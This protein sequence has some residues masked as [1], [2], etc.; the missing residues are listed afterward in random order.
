M[1]DLSTLPLSVLDIGPVM[2]GSSPAATLRNTVDL[3][4]RVEQLGYRRYWVAEHHNAGSSVTSSPAVLAGQL[5][6]ATSRIRIGSGG[7]MLPNHQPLVV[8]EQFGTLAA[9]HPGRIDLGIGR[10]PGADP[11]AALALRRNAAGADFADL[12]SEVLAYMAGGTAVAAYPVPDEWPPVWVLGSSVNGARV[13]AQFGL[14]FAFA[15]Q[16]AAPNTIPALRAYREAF[17]PSRQLDRPYAM[18]AAVVL[19]ADSDERARWLGTTLEIAHLDLMRG[20]LH[21]YVSP[22]EAEQTA[23]STAER[24]LARDWYA[25]QFVGGPATVRAKLETF[26]ADTGIDELMALTIV[27]DHAATIRSFELLAELTHR[28]SHADGD[29]AVPAGH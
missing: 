11:L 16:L 7:V 24:R 21:W 28:A 13:A 6:A 27:H 29:T 20:E 3:A 5:A 14:P 17:Q 4:V 15:H 19:V 8:A 9:L 23:Y 26:V 12:L 25:T 1:V 18:A 10:A 2:T 22:E